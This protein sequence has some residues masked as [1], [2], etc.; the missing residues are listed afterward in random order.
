MNNVLLR[1]AIGLFLAT[2]FALVVFEGRAATAPT[3][4][5][6][7]TSD[8]T[9]IQGLSI[10]D[11]QKIYLGKKRV[12]GGVLVFAIDQSEAAP[13]K[14]DF[15]DSVLHMT[16][17][18]YRQQ[19]MKRRLQEGAVIPRVVANSDE[20][21]KAVRETPGTIGYVHESEVG[22]LLGLKVLA[23]VPTK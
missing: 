21:M 6:F 15:L 10:E 20:A 8:D 14:R 5:V 1:L 2:A 13:I 11:I 12:A 17:T 7:I 3:D 23:T 22:S 9:P 18:D 19:L 16:Q 4:L